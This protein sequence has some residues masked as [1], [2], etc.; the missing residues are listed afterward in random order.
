MLTIINVDVLLDKIPLI[1]AHIST[2]A[3]N[4]LGEAKCRFWDFNMYKIQSCCI[5]E[6]EINSYKE[7]L[8]IYISI[9]TYIN[10]MT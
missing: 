6:H 10:F 3:R 7:S 5:V 4:I 9:G 2:E 8:C 1:K